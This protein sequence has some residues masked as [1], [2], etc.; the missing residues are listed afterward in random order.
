MFLR[1]CMF[2][3]AGKFGLR[4]MPATTTISNAKKNGQEQWYSACICGNLTVDPTGWERSAPE[5]LEYIEG[6]ADR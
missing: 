5:V 1:A 2:L 4:A 6:E 3:R